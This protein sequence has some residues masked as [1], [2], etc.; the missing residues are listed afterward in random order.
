[1]SNFYDQ[2]TLFPILDFHD[3]LEHS[4]WRIPCFINTAGSANQV[5]QAKLDQ[6]III[7]S[8]LFS[9]SRHVLKFPDGFIG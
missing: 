4:S 9:N 7:I 3:E 6:D 5:Y 1:M 8:Y 2:Q